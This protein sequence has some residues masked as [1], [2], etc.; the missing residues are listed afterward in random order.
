MHTTTSLKLKESDQDPF[1]GTAMENV[2]AFGGIRVLRMR[3][4]FCC[5]LAV[6]V[7]LVDCYDLGTM[8]YLH[9]VRYIL[10]S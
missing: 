7:G 2:N 6:R 8:K 1:L 9:M 3:L 10:R 5:V 4:R